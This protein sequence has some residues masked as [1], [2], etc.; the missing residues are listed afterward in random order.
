MDTISIFKIESHSSKNTITRARESGSHEDSTRSTVRHS[1]ISISSVVSNDS[2]SVQECLALRQQVEALQL[3]AETLQNTI[4]SLEKEVD[5]LKNDNTTLKDLIMSL[6]SQILE[7]RE[8]S[9]LHRLDSERHRNEFWVFARLFSDRKA[10]LAKDHQEELK[11]LQEKI[12]TLEVES[13]HMSRQ[14]LRYCQHNSQLC[15]LVDSLNIY[16]SEIETRFADLLQR[17]CSELGTLRSQYEDALET[18]RSLKLSHDALKGELDIFKAGIHRAA[19][20]LAEL[21]TRGEVS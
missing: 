20:F 10:T 17:K 3:H 2:S 6:N 8:E 18:T 14:Y 9:E 19:A 4:A 21:G 5:H 1:S 13:I 11:R 16:V 7:C 12:D 15:Q